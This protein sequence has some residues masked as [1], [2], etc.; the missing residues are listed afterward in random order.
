MLVNIYQRSVS[1]YMSKNF[2]EIYV[3]EMLAN[4]YQ[5]NVSKYLSK[6]N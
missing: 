4:I 3:R 5:R 1:N 6:K 2:L